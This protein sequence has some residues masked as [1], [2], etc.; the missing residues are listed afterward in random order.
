M[1]KELG[2]GIC[3]NNFE[4]SVYKLNMSSVENAGVSCCNLFLET[5]PEG[6]AR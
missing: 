2:C 6:Y 1:S 4:F 5:K 3:H